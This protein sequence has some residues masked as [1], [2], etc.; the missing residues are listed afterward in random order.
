MTGPGDPIPDA[1]HRR[2]AHCGQ[3][4]VD[5]RAAPDVPGQ[6][7]LCN[8]CWMNTRPAGPPPR[9]GKGKR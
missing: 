7:W 8:L 1:A 4:R 2:C 6:P 3:L 5:V 9:E